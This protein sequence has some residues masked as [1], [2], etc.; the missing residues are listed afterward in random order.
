MRGPLFFLD[1]RVSAALLTFA[2]AGCVVARSEPLPDAGP[3]PV[4]AAE[5][6][7]CA[8]GSLERCAEGQWEEITRCASVCDLTLGC[9]EC[10]PGTTRCL[11]A[12]AQ[13][14][15]EAGAWEVIGV[16]DVARFEECRGGQIYTECALKEALRTNEGCTF[17]PTVTPNV[18]F[19]DGFDFAVLVA[20]PHETPVTI[21]VDRAGVPIRQETIPPRTTTE[22]V[23][24]WVI[25]LVGAG[26]GGMVIPA[27]GYRLVASRPVTVVQ[28]NAINFVTR[29]APGEGRGEQFSY[30]NDASLLFPDSVLGRNYLALLSPTTGS[31]QRV[32]GVLSSD[33]N[34]S[35]GNSGFIAITG[36]ENGTHVSVRLTAHT[37][38]AR[39]VGRRYVP[40]DVL[41]ATL[42]EGDVL[43][44]MSVEF[45]ID[46]VG[47]CSVDEGGLEKCVFG[48]ESDLTGSEIHADRPIAVYVGNQCAFV[49]W[50]TD[51]NAQPNVACDH[52]EEQLLPIEAWSR[53][54]VAAPAW[55]SS[56]GIPPTYRILSA[57]ADNQ[58]TFEPA[59]VHPT[60]ILGKGQVLTFAT[61]SPFFVRG[62]G[63]LLLAQFTPGA[64]RESVDG[65]PP[66]GDPSFS[67][68]ASPEQFLTDV[69]FL[70]PPDYPE[71]WMQVIV[72]LPR[73]PISLDGAPFEPE[74]IPIGE[75]PFAYAN[76]RIGGGV[77]TLQSAGV[78]VLMLSM[79]A[80]TSLGYVGG[81]RIAT[82]F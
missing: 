57:E 38:L 28:A 79:G 31:F 64:G 35:H 15:T 48:S 71:S 19:E 78:G 40:G 23:L 29:A 69:L 59:G 21:D 26:T 62:T 5:E 39:D 73:T 32:D 60:V 77:H 80:Y 68:L 52:L 55:I 66:I 43:L 54:G 82:L 46:G 14:C 8:G 37:Q 61:A 17:R 56:L 50:R 1:V 4:C 24:P 7:R 3:A 18:L 30:T 36:T 75:S 22:V 49:P 53:Q 34:L 70:V 6:R 11:E 63:R 27:A 45:G 51:P 44:I 47:I 65:E 12:E 41:E 2:F 67:L 9:V 42:D 10:V 25:G 81:T 74:L 20:N 16:A 76:V 72:A 33:P 13:R 58:L